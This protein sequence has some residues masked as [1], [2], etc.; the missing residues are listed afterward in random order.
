MGE[1][2]DEI[3]PGGAYYSA[4]RCWKSD[5]WNASRPYICQKVPY[6]AVTGTPIKETT[7]GIAATVPKQT[8]PDP[9]AKPTVKDV[10]SQDTIGTYLP[11]VHCSLRMYAMGNTLLYYSLAHQSCKVPLCRPLGCY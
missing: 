9:T 1:P 8:T 7:P 10:T 6:L 2:N 3:P 4:E 11:I 5:I